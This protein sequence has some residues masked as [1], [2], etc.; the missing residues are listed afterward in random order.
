MEAVIASIGGKAGELAFDLIAQE[1]AYVLNYKTNVENLKEGVDE[2][3]D[4]RRRVQQ[5]VDAAKR[6]GRK[7]YK[8]VDKWLATVDH[9]ISEM[10]G[11]ELKE[12]EE[13]AD[14]MRFI[15]LCPNF[16]SRYLLSKKAEKEAGTIAQLLEKGR[17]DTVSYLPAPQRVCIGSVN[18]FNRAM[19][20]LKNDNSAIVGVFGARR[21]PMATLVKDVA[22]LAEGKLYDKVV[23]AT[24]SQTPNIEK[25]RIE[26]ADN[27]GLNS[28]DPSLTPDAKRIQ[29]CERLQQEKV[30]VILDDIRVPFDLEALGIPTTGEDMGC[31]I[32]LTSRKSDVLS[33]MG[34]RKPFAINIFDTEE[35]WDLFRNMAGDI[36]ERYNLCCTTNEVARKCAELP[37]AIGT[38]AETLKTKKALFELKNG[39]EEL[40]SPILRSFKR[41]LGDA[42]SI[43]VTKGWV[44]ADSGQ[45]DFILGSLQISIDFSAGS[46][47]VRVMSGSNHL[48]FDLFQIQIVLESGLFQIWIKSNLNQLKL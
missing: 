42:C 3:K 43:D 14:G 34:V 38:I 25:I 35:A 1:I 19:E 11:T 23:I 13:R 6:R 44:W 39:L 4:A 27:L 30:L 48:E 16:K 37:I 22:R 31:K 28:D 20:A 40:K 7:I 36:V 17:F 2:L 41:Y 5:S 47:H 9:V 15:G 45:V 33:S 10:D 46:F 24:I 18:A 32:L 12:D 8:D 26:I 21:V 29:L